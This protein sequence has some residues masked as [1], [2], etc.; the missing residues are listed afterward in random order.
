[1][2]QVSSCR[3]YDHTDIIWD[4]QIDERDK[5]I[6]LFFRQIEDRDRHGHKKNRS[7]PISIWGSKIVCADE[8]PD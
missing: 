6:L 8:D 2:F 5:K 4:D 7:R 1:M 3:P